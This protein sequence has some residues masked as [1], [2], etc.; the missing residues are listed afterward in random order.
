MRS[1]LALIGVSSRVRSV[2]IHRHACHRRLP[3]MDACDS[4][5][6]EVSRNGLSLMLRIPDLTV[7]RLAA[8]FKVS[9]MGSAFHCSGKRCNVGRALRKLV[10]PILA[11]MGDA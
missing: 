2:G 7:T 11:C 5:R 4:R 8:V 9:V 6:V 3:D 10:L 1:A